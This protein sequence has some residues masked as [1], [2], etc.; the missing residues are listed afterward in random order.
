LLEGVQVS[1]ELRAKF[2]QI[3]DS[4]CDISLSGINAVAAGHNRQVVQMCNNLEV[5][6]LLASDQN[7][8]C[9]ILSS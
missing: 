9:K 7:G 5:V 1:G 4:F 2:L 6:V 3:Q 8:N